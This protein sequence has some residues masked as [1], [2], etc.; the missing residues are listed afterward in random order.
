MKTIKRVG[1][2]GSYSEVVVLLFDPHLLRQDDQRI[3][4]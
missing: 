1:F 2:K 4:I 3:P